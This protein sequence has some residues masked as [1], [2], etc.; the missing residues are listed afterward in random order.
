[1]LSVVARSEGNLSA[2]LLS[3]FSKFLGDHDGKLTPK[4]ESRE[5]QTHFGVELREEQ[6]QS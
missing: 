5:E 6:T 1:M 3:T 2:F 4:A